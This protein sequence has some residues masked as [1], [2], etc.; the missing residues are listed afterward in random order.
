M[1]GFKVRTGE[2]VFG[3]KVSQRGLNTSLLFAGNKIIGCSSEENPE[4]PTMGRVVCLDLSQIDPKTQEPKE[5]WKIDG[6]EA[7]FPSPCIDPE[8]K[9]AF[10]PD[11]KGTVHA[12]DIATG[13]LLWKQGTGTI[14]RPSLVWADGKIYAA[15]ANGKFAVIQI[16]E[17]GKRPKVLSKIELGADAQTLGRE[18]FIFGSPA[19]ANGRIYL[20]TAAG[21]YAI[22]PRQP[23]KPTETVPPLPDD[24]QAGQQVAA[25]Q[26]V[27]FDA[28]VKA[29]DK[30]QFSVRTFDAKGR[31]NGENVKAE[32]AIEQL[33]IPPPPN[34]PP[35]TALGKA[36]NLRGKVDANGLFTSE[37]G[38][39]Q[40]G[41]VAAKVGAA[42]G[43]GRVRVMPEPPYTMDFEQAPVGKPPLT[44]V[45]AAGKFAI[46]DKN[47]NKVVVKTLNLDLYH[48]ART[49]FGRKEMTNYTIES[50]VM[51]GKQDVAG[52]I[53]MPDVGI[54]NGRYTF[55]LHG[56]HQ[57]TSLVAWTGALPK[58]G[59]LG[60]A[61]NRIVPFK[62]AF[63]TW[64]RMKLTVQQENGSAMIRGKV[65]KKGDPEPQN[66]TIEL[67]DPTPN[68]SGSPGLFG[69][70]LVTPYKSEI[71]YDNIVVKPN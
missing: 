12:I 14:G 35:N 24:G 18:Y 36:G 69:E 16:P 62:W 38:P 68:R 21:I 6:I 44:W 41:A 64:Y 2:R 22:G 55:V 23:T 70:S 9:T 3:Y 50:D 31:L 7:G 45:N 51:V 20:Q 54:V 53:F 40:G 25:V 63:D 34:S 59:Q 67:K 61:L 58:E 11:N 52:A 57:N 17:A 27:P 32:W 15:E 19:I 60:G 33:T 42:N 8:L 37:K 66:W 13:K 65:W 49:F 71:Y 48:L 39:I 47:G 28:I 26:V 5:A 4:S 10:V 56:N 1:Y 43:I 30:V 29:G 46:A